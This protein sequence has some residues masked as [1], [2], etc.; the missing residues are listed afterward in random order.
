MTASH[1]WLPRCLP[2]ACTSTLY[3]HI[4]GH[5]SL[6]PP[7]PV[8][9]SIIPRLPPNCLHEDRTTRITTSGR[10]AHQ[11]VGLAVAVPTD[12]L[13]AFPTVPR[14]PSLSV[15]LTLPKRQCGYYRSGATRT[16]RVDPS[17]HDQSRLDLKRSA[18]ANCGG[19]TLALSVTAPCAV[20][21]GGFTCES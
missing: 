10:P 18:V 5:S 4:A 7:P 14:M 16:T 13:F 20:L 19:E 6:P 1:Q 17:V 9:L 3:T 12:R 11:A 21:T 2:S 8:P 15:P